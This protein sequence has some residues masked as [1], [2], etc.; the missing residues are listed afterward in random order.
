MLVWGGDQL[1]IN[2]YL[3]SYWK[4]NLQFVCHPLIQVVGLVVA[5]QGEKMREGEANLFD[6]QKK[7]TIFSYESHMSSS[8]VNLLQERALG[9]I[10]LFCFFYLLIAMVVE[11]TFCSD[12]N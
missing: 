6:C 10:L 8:G 7:K 2:I 9:L 3:V 5:K 12:V 11:I 4:E 1:V